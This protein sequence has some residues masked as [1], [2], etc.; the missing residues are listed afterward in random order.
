[1]GIRVLL[2]G[3]AI[4]LL[5][6]TGRR[7]FRRLKSRHA[8]GRRP[9]TPMVNMVSCHHCGLHLPQNEALEKDSRY[10]CCREHMQADDV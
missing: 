4:W 8:E 1:M 9:V 6:L 2:L 5:F 7:L 3:I 10:Y